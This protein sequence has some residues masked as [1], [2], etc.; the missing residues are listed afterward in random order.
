MDF[1][2]GAA[3]ARERPGDHRPAV[4]S[5]RGH[6]LPDRPIAVRRRRRGH[7][8]S[9]RPNDRHG[10]GRG[11][12][13]RPEPARAGGGPHRHRPSGS[14]E[15]SAV[16]GEAPPPRLN[17]GDP[18]RRA[19]RRP[20]LRP[21]RDAPGWVPGAALGRARGRRDRDPGMVEDVAG[22]A[23]EDHPAEAAETAAAGDDDAAA[24]VV[25]GSRDLACRVAL[26]RRPGRVV[27]GRPKA[28]TRI[29]G[30]PAGFVDRLLALVAGGVDSDIG[31]RLS[32]RRPAASAWR[33]RRYRTWTGR[34]T[35]AAPR[36]GR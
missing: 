36:P 16:R 18:I 2:R 35:K 11:R 23:A 12:T 10:M 20:A 8:A 13:V 34:S 22:D 14:P 24:E 30:M 25:S 19:S 5:G 31:D 9:P 32:S 27:A 3:L 15:A 28:A 6:H 26:T 4:D 21:G 1:I 7:D 33:A 29:E 17:Q